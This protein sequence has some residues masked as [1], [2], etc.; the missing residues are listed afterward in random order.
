[1]VNEMNKEYYQKY[2]E[3]NIF[4][5]LK[6]LQPAKSR[7]VLLYCTGQYT[8]KKIAELIGVSSN[9]ITAWLM[10]PEVMEIIEEIQKREFGIIESSLKAIRNRAVNTMTELMDSP[11]DG[12]RYQASKDIL[13]RTGHKPT[14]KVQ[15]DK[16]VTTIEEQLKSISHMQECD[17]EI[18][19]VSDIVE[20][21]K[22]GQ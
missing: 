15:V 10:Q 1:M 11:M 2:R 18:I 4:Y 17:A 21:V 9:T 5:G 7:M 13:D 19:D 22:N 6:P 12:V 14:T 3:D 20:L 8:N 16:T